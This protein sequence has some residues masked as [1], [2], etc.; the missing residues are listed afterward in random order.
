LRREKRCT[1]TT[2]GKKIYIYNSGG[3]IVVK[4]KRNSGNM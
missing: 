1:Y 4:K 2:V 3:K